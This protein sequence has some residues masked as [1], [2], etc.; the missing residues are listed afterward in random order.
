[1]NRGLFYEQWEAEEHGSYADEVRSLTSPRWRISIK[2]WHPHVVALPWFFALVVLLITVVLSP[3][4]FLRGQS[5]SR[6]SGQRTGKFRDPGVPG[7]PGQTAP[8]PVEKGYKSRA[9]PACQ[10][11][12][13]PSTTPEEVVFPP[14]SQLT[15]SQ[16]C[17]Q[18]FLCT[19][20]PTVVAVG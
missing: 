5:S 8:G 14:S 10:F 15:S 3:Y 18:Q 11:T 7:G 1:M 2:P 9:G 4:R 16:P 17:S 6:N 20:P 13:H 12:V 19:A